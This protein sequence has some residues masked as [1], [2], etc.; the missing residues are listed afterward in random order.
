[1]K[2]L[3]ENRTIGVIV[4]LVII[5]FAMSCKKKSPLDEKILGTWR[6]KRANIHSVFSFRANGSWTASERVEGRFSKIVENKGKIVGQW[7]IVESEEEV[8][9]I[10]MT[11]TKVDS[12][13]DWKVE[14]PVRLEILGVDDKELNLRYENGKKMKL[15]RVRG[16]KAS[17]EEVDEGIAKIKTGPIVVN[18]K[19][20][21]AHGKFRYLCIDLELSV[22]DVENC[23]Y[24]AGEKIAA[25]KDQET[26]GMQYTLHPKIREVAIMFFSSLTYKEA[27]TLSKVK[28]VVKN[29]Q[30][31]LNPYLD[32]NLTDIYVV[33]VVVTTN[34]ESVKEFQ[35]MYIPI[36]S[37]ETETEEGEE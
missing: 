8:L 12:V 34:V 10:V 3:T 21:R 13:K 27:K 32:G 5:S 7:E 20:D 19:R 23:N 4:I 17:A 33:K 9:Y 22:E 1:M 24:I 29:F 14:T 15:V 6:I 30:A 16:K 18:L 35:N 28:E 26:E 25:E 2:C 37:E 11:P 36:D 31:I